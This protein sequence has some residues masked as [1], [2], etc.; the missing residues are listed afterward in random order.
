[1]LIIQGHKFQILV[2]E[3]E[4]NNYIIVIIILFTNEKPL[5]NRKE[6]L[7]NGIFAYDGIEYVYNLGVGRPKYFYGFSTLSIY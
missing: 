2:N 1:M 3:D 7:I 6:F 5:I 4:D